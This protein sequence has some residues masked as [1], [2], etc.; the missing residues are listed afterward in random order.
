MKQQHTPGPWTVEEGREYT[1]FVIE[2]FEPA[3][4]VQRWGA[5]YLD[6][7]YDA[8]RALIESAPDMYEALCYAQGEA[9]GGCGECQICFVLDKVRGESRY[10]LTDEGRNAVTKCSECGGSPHVYGCS[11]YAY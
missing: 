3:E 1:E 6:V 4:I 10:T 11:F 7:V 2:Q 9:C 8:N 5:D